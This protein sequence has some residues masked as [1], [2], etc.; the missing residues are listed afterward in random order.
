M[1]AAFYDILANLCEQYAN[2][3]LGKYKVISEGI[4]YLQTSTT[5][6]ISIKDIA[7]MCSVSEC[8]FRRLFKE[9][10]GMSPVEY[11][12]RN[13]IQKAKTHLRYDNI[14][15]AE[16]ASLSGFSDCSYFTKKF[17]EYTGK[18]PGEYKKM[19]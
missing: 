7:E 19:Y 13:K 8:Y 5:S 12:T 15:I 2:T 14:S 1:K 16:I 9:Y 3:D 17:H 11:L 4:R 18:T 10:S 6:D